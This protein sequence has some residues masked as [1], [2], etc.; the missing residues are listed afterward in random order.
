MATL[1]PSHG[2]IPAIE[3]LPAIAWLHQP[4]NGWFH[5]SHRMT[6]HVTSTEPSNG[7]QPSHGYIPNH[8]M[9]TSHRMATQTHHGGVQAH[10]RS[11]AGYL[12]HFGLS[13]AK[14]F[15]D[16]IVGVV[17]LPMI[18][19]LFLPGLSGAALFDGQLPNTPVLALRCDFSFC[20]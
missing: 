4:I 7:Y 5:N 15:D 13:C 9:A 17:E 2:Y 18:Q 20:M 19:H 10:Y 8:S 16:F 6:T 3:W 11:H 1:Q 12:P 14:F